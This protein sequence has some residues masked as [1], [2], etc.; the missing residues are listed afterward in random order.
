MHAQ[1]IIR[2]AAGRTRWRDADLQLLHEAQ[3]TMF[4]LQHRPGAS[5][6][7]VARACRRAARRI[8]NLGYA[9]ELAG[10]KDWTCTLCCT[11][12]ARGARHTYAYITRPAYVQYRLCAACRPLED[13]THE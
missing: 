1:A 5:P 8:I 4:R 3:T 6:A 7:L 9:S 11:P 2:D 10:T 12:I 13:P